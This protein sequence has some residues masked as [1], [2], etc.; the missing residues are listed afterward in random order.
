MASV[1]SLDGS[2][3]YLR[4]I[5]WFCEGVGAHVGDKW[6]VGGDFGNVLELNTLYRFV[7][8]VITIIRLGI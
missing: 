5:D 3:S 4:D 2:A 7:D 1:D 8:A 6:D